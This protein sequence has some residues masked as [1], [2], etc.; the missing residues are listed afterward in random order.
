MGG[1]AFESDWQRRGNVVRDSEPSGDS[2]KDESD[3][4]KR[5]KVSE[6][7]AHDITARSR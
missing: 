1:C 3:G 5:G 2:G 6:E 4:D 7:G